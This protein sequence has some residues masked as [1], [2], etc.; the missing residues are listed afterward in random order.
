MAMGYRASN[1]GTESLMMALSPMFAM[2]SAMSVKT[3]V[4]PR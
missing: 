4:Q 3:M 1:T 2:T